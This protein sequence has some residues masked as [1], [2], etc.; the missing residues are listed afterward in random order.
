ME[1]KEIQE[2]FEKYVQQFFPNAEI[3][4]YKN[5]FLQALHQKR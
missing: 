1:D 3:G 4:D 2:I 5:A